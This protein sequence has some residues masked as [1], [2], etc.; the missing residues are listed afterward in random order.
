MNNKKWT[1]YWSR[2][3]RGLGLIP[4]TCPKH[5][6]LTFKTLPQSQM[7]R[8]RFAAMYETQPINIA[9]VY[10]S[11]KKTTCHITFQGQQSYL[12]KPQETL[13]S[14]DI[15]ISQMNQSQLSIDYDI[16][17]DDSYHFVSGFEAMDYDVFESSPQQIYGLT[18]IELQGSLQGCLCVFGDSIVE[19]GHYTRILQ[20]EYMKKGYSVI[21]L[22]LSGNRLLRQIEYVDL[23]DTDN[24]DVLTSL[25][26]QV[27]QNISIDKQCFGVSGV[28]RFVQDAMDCHN[29]AQMIIAI[30][31]NDIYQPGTFCANINELPTSQQMSEGYLQLQTLIKDIPTLW[32]MITPFINNPHWTQDKE[33]LRQEVNQW[34]CR[35]MKQT[36]CL[37]DLTKE[38]FQDDGL[39]PNLIG[40]KIIAKEIKKCIN[41]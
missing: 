9:N 16:I 41:I 27:Y 28:K 32:C 3:Q 8:L 30:G 34:L 39:H 29:I 37:D 35:E 6:H 38:D 11:D 1:T 31:V 25:P 13:W 40:G 15:D 2:S 7:I 33:K 36:V 23:N 4:T 5:H 12:L 22:G 24:P 14:D 21:N 20:E 19:Q 10:I 17:T 26:Q 18:H